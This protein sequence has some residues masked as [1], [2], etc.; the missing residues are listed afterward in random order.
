V[1]FAKVMD[2]CCIKMYI[3]VKNIALKNLF[4]VYKPFLLFLLKFFVSYLILT[5]IYQQYL[6]SYD[7]AIFEVD[8]FTQTVAQQTKWITELFGFEVMTE[9]HTEQASV[10]FLI[11]DNYVSRVVEGCNALAVMILFV[12]FVIAFKG[13]FRKTI[14]FTVM[15]I[16]A[17]HV[18]NILRISFISIAIYKYPEY[19]HF[20]HGVVFPLI[21]YGFVFLLWVLWVKKFSLYADEQP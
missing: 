10:K 19:Q 12:A 3:F 18:L 14:A 17:I 1:F 20:L 15:G 7:K 11:N 21:I 9:N 16:L 8:A 13:K 2:A 4:L 5:F 6:Q